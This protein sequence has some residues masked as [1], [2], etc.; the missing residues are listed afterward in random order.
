MRNKLRTSKVW[1][2]ITFTWISEASYVLHVYTETPFVSK[3]ASLF[4]DKGQEK[5]KPLQYYLISLP[6]LTNM[7][8]LFLCCW[9]ALGGE[10]MHRYPSQR[11]LMCKIHSF[12]RAVMVYEQLTCKHP[13][14]LWP[15]ASQCPRNTGNG[16][17]AADR[18]KKQL[19]TRSQHPLAI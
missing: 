15:W 11:W 4:A 8:C 18:L 6:S 12:H 9:Y 2:G 17:W 5:Y 7:I 19:S 13:W 3:W 1:I 10:R 14:F 16:K